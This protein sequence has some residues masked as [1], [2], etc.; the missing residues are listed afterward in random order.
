M[1]DKLTF[2]TNHRCPWAHRAHIALAELG[3]PF[4]EV[5]ID[6]DR[7][8][9]PW[10][11]EVN[12]RG[13][14]PSI[15]YGDEI[16][17]ESAVVAQFLADLHPDKAP[18][19]PTSTAAGGPLAR[20]RIAFFVDTYFT[21]VHSHV[22]KLGQAKTADEQAAAGDAIV[23]A[24]VKELEPLLAGGAKS[25]S[26][27]AAKPFFGGSERL[28]LAEVLT[29]SFVLRLVRLSKLGV[30]PSNVPAAAAEKAP[31]F[32]AWAEAVAAH[33]SVTG[34]FDEKVVAASTKARLD[35][36]RAA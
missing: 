12:P 34:I 9:D 35:K 26:T 33:P 10:Y 31:A 36:Q 5:I 32:W 16:I 15:K 20:A 13:L 1:A 14:V 8:R 27:P 18:L 11:L 7:P 23:A 17:T 24:A 6:L 29:G 21:K 30:Y 22:I 19:V 28:T 3:I 4:E 25:A 2:Y